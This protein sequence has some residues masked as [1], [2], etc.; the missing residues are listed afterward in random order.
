MLNLSMNGEQ[1]KVVHKNFVWK[2]N[3]TAWLNITDRA[4][5]QRSAFIKR[6]ENGD[7]QPSESDIYY[8]RWMNACGLTND[9]SIKGYLE[10]RALFN[11]PG[12]MPKSV[13]CSK[14]GRILTDKVSIAVGAGKKCRGK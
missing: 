6:A 3:F 2:G 8:A 13:R 14:C 9:E 5:G 11:R 1:I 10:R 7:K 4:I 12:D